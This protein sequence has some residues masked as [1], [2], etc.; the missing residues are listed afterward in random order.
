MCISFSFHPFMSF[1][2]YAII[3]YLYM[4][5]YIL[6][7]YLYVCNNTIS[8]S[9]LY[10]VGIKHVWDGYENKYHECIRVKLFFITGD[11]PALTLMAHMQA[12]GG[13]NGCIK[14][15]HSD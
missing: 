12:H 10:H 13:L 14:C 1:E 15:N 9:S 5:I 6:C 8:V 7:I 4:Y 3:I 2:L 11:Y